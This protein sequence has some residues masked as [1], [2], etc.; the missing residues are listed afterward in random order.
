[1]QRILARRPRLAGP[2]MS[3]PRTANM[4]RTPPDKCSFALCGS[5]EGQLEYK[6]SDVSQGPAWLLVEKVGPSITADLVEAFD[7]SPS[8]WPPSTCPVV[9]RTCPRPAVGHLRFHAHETARGHRQVS[10]RHEPCCDRGLWSARPIRM[11]IF[12]LAEQGCFVARILSQ[13]AHDV[14]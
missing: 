9:S 7:G 12:D 11:A 5:S 4:L 2:R 14:D 3:V 6:H 13:S 1:V 10:I 8:H